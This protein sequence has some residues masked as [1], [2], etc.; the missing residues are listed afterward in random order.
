MFPTRRPHAGASGARCYDASGGVDE[1]VD[2]G[3]DVD[4]DRA[5]LIRVLT[6]SIL[7]LSLMIM[8]IQS[9]WVTYFN[10][11]GFLKALQVSTEPLQVGSERSEQRP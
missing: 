2:E 4:D 3:V 1:R 6:A 8:I 11:A 5:Q 10:T 7:V 9:L